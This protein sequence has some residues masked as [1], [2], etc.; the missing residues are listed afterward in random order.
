MTLEDF[1]PKKPDFVA[2]MSVAVW[3]NQDRNGN[4]YLAI[5]L[6]WGVVNAFKPKDV[7]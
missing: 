7:R 1:K 6:P 3:I 5:K 2:D 4:D